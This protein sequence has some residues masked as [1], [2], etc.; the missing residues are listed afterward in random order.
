MALIKL[1]L[2]FI[3]SWLMATATMATRDTIMYA[4]PGYNLEARL[5]NEG[6]GLGDC[7]NALFEFKSCTNE[8]VLFFLNGKGYIGIDCFKSIRVI[9]RQCWPYMFTSLG[10]TAEEGDILQGYCDAPPPVTP[11]TS[12]QSKAQA[13]LGS[14]GGL[15]DKSLKGVINTILIPNPAGPADP[16]VSNFHPFCVTYSAHSSKGFEGR[17]S[18][19]SSSRS[20]LCYSQS[21]SSTR[22]FVKKSATAYPFSE[23]LC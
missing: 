8:I 22:K 11:P 10:F 19:T 17:S 12:M 2:V 3:L 23:T 6:G 21:R 5:N 20:G 15:G 13:T 1:V 14:V 7:W 16:S 18:L 9:T 4:K